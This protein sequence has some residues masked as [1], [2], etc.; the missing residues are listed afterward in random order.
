MYILNSYENSFNK[1]IAVPTD[2][3]EISDRFLVCTSYDK[4]IRLDT[5]GT[6]S[7]L[8]GL[9]F[10]HNDQESFISYKNGLLDLPN[11]MER[12]NNPWNVY[13]DQEEYAKMQDSI[14][15]MTRLK[16][17]TLCSSQI[18]E[19][20][21]NTGSLINLENLILSESGIKEFSEIISR[22]HR[23]KNLDLS[24]TE[25]TALPE[26]IYYLKRLESLNLSGT[27]I[28]K[29]PESLGNLYHLKH[30]YINGTGITELPESIRYLTDLESL[31]LSGTG[32]KEFPEIMSRL[33]QLKNLDLSRTAITVFP[34]IIGYLYRLESLNLSGTGINK[35]PESLAELYHLKHLDIN[36][37]GITVLPDS[38]CDLIKLKSLNLSGTGINELPKSI[39]KLRY[40]K[41]LDISGTGITTLPNSLRNMM[42]LE[43]FNI[44]NTR[45]IKL[46]EFIGE[47]S[48]L[49]N[50]E[51]SN[52][53]IEELPQSIGELRQLIELNLSN[54]QIVK[55]PET[56][57]LPNNL[58]RLNLSGSQL[59]ELPVNIG[60]LKNLESLNISGTRLRRLPYEIGGLENLVEL[61]ISK[62]QL[63]ELPETMRNLTRLKSLDLS[64]TRIHDIGVLSYLHSLSSI[65]MWETMVD[66]ISCLSKLEHLESLNISI[67]PV[68]DISSLKKLHSLS[69]LDISGTQVSDISGLI[70]ATSLSELNMAWIPVEDI[71]FLSSLTRLV[72]INLFETPI[73]DIGSLGELKG[74]RKINISRT[75]L[76]FIPESF[77]DLRIDFT[78][79]EMGEEDGIYI[80]DLSLRNDPIEVFFQSRNTIIEYLKNRNNKS[81]DRVGECKVIFL[82]NGNAGKSTAVH[83][84]LNAGALSE[85]NE[86]GTGVEVNEI[87]FLK[88]NDKITL[89]I[90]DFD[91]H[92]VFHSLHRLFLS[93]RSVYVIFLNA[94][95]TSLNESA[96][97]W[98]REVKAY[99]NGAP[100]LL[101]INKIDHNRLAF[102]DEY[103][104]K[105]YYPFLSKI[106]RL[107]AA[108]DSIDVFNTELVESIK[109]CVTETGVVNAKIPHSWKRAIETLRNTVFS[110]ISMDRFKQ[111]CY[112]C[113]VLDINE[114]WQPLL[115]WI[116][117]LGVGFS[118]LND[119]S[120][121]EDLIIQPL[122]LINAIHT[123]IINGRN[124]SNNGI[125]QKSDIYQLFSGLKETQMWDSV[126]FHYSL[127]E[128]SCILGV[129]H[130]IEISFENPDGTEFFPLFCDHNSSVSHSDVVGNNAVHYVYKY[131]YLPQSVIHRLIVKM[132]ND[133]DYKHVWY[134]G[135]VFRNKR[136]IAY[137]NASH[138]IID[139]YVI[140]KDANHSAT[141]YW[142]VLRS[143][144]LQINKD[145]TLNPKYYICYGENGLE[146]EFSYDDLLSM[147]RAGIYKTYSQHL[148]R[149]VPVDD[150]LSLDNNANTNIVDDVLK[151]IISIQSSKS[152]INA[153]EEQLNLYTRDLLEMK[154]FYCLDQR[155]IRKNGQVSEIDLNILDPRTNKNYL[156]ESTII[157]SVH[158]AILDSHIKKLLSYYQNKGNAELFFITYIRN[159]KE[160]FEKISNRVFDYLLSQSQINSNG[161]IF[162]LYQ[163]EK[164]NAVNQ[165]LQYI[166]TTYLFKNIPFTIY[167]INARVMGSRDLNDK[168]T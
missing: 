167:Y 4:K 156:L 17:L 105:E 63:K 9:S 122:W 149:L 159:D 121:E 113:G 93:Q 2:E 80:K 132:Q 166:K 129:L 16:S 75:N 124:V 119:N 96:K 62:T 44:C 67:T 59:R 15:N 48:S 164:P 162:E 138:N 49:H 3:I 161:D 131:D 97:Y 84:I 92:A 153:N 102:V 10:R 57:Y 53:Q 130:R 154:G 52:S 41:K 145:M 51:L 6:L 39:G 55:F 142:G 22:L 150:I 7:V 151:C 25:I 29:L 20:P 31:N 50:L 56:T 38:I 35:L 168:T 117:D 141:E 26:S 110:F 115:D 12:Y 123:I 73:S 42:N 68:T 90:W 27:G 47:L 107:S 148:N 104:L 78:N 37:T 109:N 88:N 18:T 99:A 98:L 19:L 163:F 165:F 23:L 5:I 146:D 87:H 60:E 94:G 83:R 46:P 144:I 100:V 101:V 126:D 155:K 106:I 143:E 71:S 76:D 40:L 120:K 79:Q 91:G 28:N 33:Y 116:V 103:E 135:A 85:H 13:L 69:R 157:T 137:V 139:I 147:R 45:I 54:S 11:S 1:I 133:L 61:D 111:I 114:V 43:D 140:S 24:R 160:A 118:F 81:M 58:I 64:C 127:Y 136:F 86:N 14:G 95:D 34:E 65:E 82:G 77:L 128:I 108:K 32:I 89:S 112:E 158:K 134:Q 74:L 70:G 72:S 66:D 152:L 21:N 8:E 125:V 36:G 30:L